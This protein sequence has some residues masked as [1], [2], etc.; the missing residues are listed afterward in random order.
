MNSLLLIH[1]STSLFMSGVIWIIQLVHYPS[2]R[3]ISEVSFEDFCKFHVRSISFIV[4]PI[5]VT[6][7][8]TS[9]FL[10]YLNF[11]MYLFINVVINFLIWISTFF[12]SVPLHEKLS[13]GYEIHTIDKLIATNWFRTILWNLKSLLLIYYVYIK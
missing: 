5:M 8:A 13:S 9:L 11:N 4:M 1:F 2:F 10:L 7:L 3:Y 6:E 12:L